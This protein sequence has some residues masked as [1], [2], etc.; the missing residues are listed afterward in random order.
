MAKRTTLH[1]PSKHMMET[2]ER[3]ASAQY[4][5]GTSPEK[6]KNFYFCGDA[7]SYVVHYVDGARKD[8]TF[9]DDARYFD[10]IPTGELMRRTQ[11]S[12]GRAR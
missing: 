9:Y 7:H 6:D 10:G 12:L 4:V 1:C 8:E 2:V 5:Q 3:R 11:L